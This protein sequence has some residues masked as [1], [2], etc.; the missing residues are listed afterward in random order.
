LLGGKQITNQPLLSAGSPAPGGNL[1]RGRSSVAQ[2]LSKG[3]MKMRTKVATD[4]SEMARTIAHLTMLLGLTRKTLENV[5][6]CERSLNQDEL[7][8]L[9]AELDIQPVA[10]CFDIPCFIKP[11]SAK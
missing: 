11:I 5:K 3:E 4:K 8:R 6:R 2:K 1:D 9:I 10:S 7:L